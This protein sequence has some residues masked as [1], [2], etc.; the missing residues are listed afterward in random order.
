MG[1]VFWCRILAPI[2][3]PRLVAHTVCAALPP[4]KT[5]HGI[6]HQKRGPI[7]MAMDLPG[8]RLHSAPGMRPGGGEGRA[9]EGGHSAAGLDPQTG[10]CAHGGVRPLQGAPT[11][12]GSCLHRAAPSVPW[13]PVASQ[14]HISHCLHPLLLAWQGQ[15]SKL[16]QR[17][18]CNATA[19]HP[20]AR[21]LPN[22]SPAGGAKM[23]VRLLFPVT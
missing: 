6:R 14:G 9:S 13:P 12:P 10:R 20:V 17:G 11:R 1:S 5:G 3:G 19:V 18:P 22:E 16:L 15:E 4:P 23:G 21:S 7:S 8:R 2:L